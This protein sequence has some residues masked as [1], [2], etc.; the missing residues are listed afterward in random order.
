[1][2]TPGES[3]LA[4]DA[5]AGDA[6]AADRQ[7]AGGGAFAHG[8]E[9]GRALAQA[10]RGRGRWQGQ[11]GH[12]ADGGAGGAAEENGRRAQS[13]VYHSQAQG[14]LVCPTT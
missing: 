5:N 7:G 10:F 4:G 6:N 3:L 1:M 2:F 14:A 9:G 11:S 8:G 13:Q 12:T